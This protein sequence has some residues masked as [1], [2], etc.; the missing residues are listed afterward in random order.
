MAYWWDEDVISLR[1]EIMNVSRQYSARQSKNMEQALRQ[2]SDTKEV[3][4][5]AREKVM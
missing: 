1:E 5:K 3:A 2:L 4:F